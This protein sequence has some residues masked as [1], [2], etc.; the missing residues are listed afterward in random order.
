[1]SLLRL[2]RTFAGTLVTA[3]SLS[4]MAVGQGGCNTL[5]LTGLQQADAAGNPLGFLINT[6]TAGNTL[7]GIRL[8]DGRSVYVY[9]TFENNGNINEI[10]GAVLRDTD[11][12]E[13]GV[14][15]ENGRP[16]SAYGFDGTTVD[17]TY[18]EVSTT[19]LK[20]RV[21]VHFADSK[22]AEEDRDQTID[23][24]VDLEQAAADLAQHVAD[25][26]GLTVSDAE[27]PT[28]PD[29]RARLPDDPSTPFGKDLSRSQLFLYFVPFY[30]FAF[31]SIGFACMQVMV[32]LVAVLVSTMV[33]VVLT[34]TKAII[35]AAF[36]P[37][38]IM[39]EM[40][41]MVFGMAT[42]AIDFDL[43]IDVGLV[44]RHPR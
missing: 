41:R 12:R 2:H 14:V 17:I 32:Q 1:M 28:A 4:I 39:C 36:S 24:D 3:F 5:S 15:F 19:R 35:I 7:G 20:G 13:A 40:M 27:P 18:E 8:A 6:D 31:M 26:L 29:G 22:V 38:I 34:L 30:Q 16:V 33:G 37:F 11:G 25:V 9:G 42:V 44:P 10:T 21:D 43:E 23:F